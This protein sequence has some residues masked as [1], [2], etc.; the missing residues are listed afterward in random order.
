ANI[1]PG[2]IIVV[3]G[4]P[5]SGKTGILLDFIYRNQANF[6]IYYFCS[7]MGTDELADRLLSFEGIDLDD[8]TFEAVEACMSVLLPVLPMLSDP[9]V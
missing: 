1:Y 3:A 9:I 8:W 4:S 7:E 5:N 6:P 2:N